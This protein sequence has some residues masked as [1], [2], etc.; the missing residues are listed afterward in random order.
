MA[1]M[2]EILDKLRDAIQASP[3]SRYRL[4]QETGVEQSQLSRFM[5]GTR[6]LGAESIEKLAE[7]LGYEIII[8]KKRGK[9]KQ[10]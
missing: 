1:S 4:S 9:R 3:K 6:G 2:S 8:R 7:A 5:A 10:V